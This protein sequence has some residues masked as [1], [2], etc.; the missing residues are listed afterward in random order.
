[1]T[2]DCD[3]L[4]VSGGWNPN[5]Q[6]FAQA[7]GRLRFDPGLAAP[8]PDESDAAVACA[9]AANGIFSLAAC[10]AEGEK[11]GARAAA[12]CGFGLSVDLTHPGRAPPRPSP[13]AGRKGGGIDRT[14]DGRHRQ[15]GPGTRRRRAAD[16]TRAVRR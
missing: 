3:L 2:L 6:L 11:A 8:V 16:P 15:E 9:G 10:L 4:A 1:M 14:R 12:L 13:P 7:R 5:V